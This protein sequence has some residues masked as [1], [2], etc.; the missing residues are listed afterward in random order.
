ML[1]NQNG[2]C[3][4]NFCKKKINFFFKGEYQSFDENEYTSESGGKARVIDFIKKKH[5]YDKVVMIGDGWTDY[6][7]CPPAVIFLK[8]F[9]KLVLIRKYL[10]WIY[11]FWWKRGT[12]KCQ[13]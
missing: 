4:L 10:E 8:N 1:F 6:E 5:G 11:W 2:I 9:L 7:S 13:V 12:R 3:N